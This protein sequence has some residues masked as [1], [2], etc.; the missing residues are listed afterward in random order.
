MNLSVNWIKQYLTL[1]DITPKDLA[2][3]LTMA[4]VEVEEVVEQAKQLEGIVVGQ[5]KEIVKHPQADKL[6]ICNTAIGRETVQ[7]VCG[8]SNLKENMLV[9]V[10]T[11]GSK[12]RWHGQGD[13]VTL[14]PA[15][16]RGQASHGMIVASSEIG[17]ED[18]FPAASDHIIL[19]LSGFP[20][21]PGMPLSEALGLN[22]VILEIDNKSVTH[23]PD[24]WGQY[25]LAREL[26]AVY[27]T[28]LKALKI[29]SLKADKETVDLQLTASAEACFRLSAV[30][31]D[32]VTVGESPWWLK[33]A[34]H[35]VGIRSIN[36]IVDITNYV[37]FD[38]GHPLHAFDL[39]ATSGPIE[40]K[41]LTKSQNITT[42]DGVK[43]KL[44]PGMV[45]FADSKQILDVAG[46]MG[47][48]SSEIKSST[49]QVLLTCANFQASTIRRMSTA[50]GLRT[51]ASSRYEKSLD[52][53]LTPQA[54]AQAVHLIKQVC[55]E[56]VVASKI[57]DINRA[58]DFQRTIVVPKDM[59]SRL[60]GVAIPDAT[61]KHIL[62]RLHF[63]VINKGKDWHVS[64]PSFR[65]TKDIGIPEDL[66]EE[67][68]RIYGYEN[69]VPVMPVITLE[70]PERNVMFQLERQLK[71]LLVLHG[72]YFEVV[73]YSFA[74]N[75]WAQF[76][77]LTDHQVALANYLSDDQKF[78]RTSLLPGLL[79]KVEEN[80]RWSQEF[81]FYEIGRIYRAEKGE[82]ATDGSDK[83]FLPDQP[84]MLAGVSISRDK[85]AQTLYLETKGL[86]EQILQHYSLPYEFRSE[87]VKFGSQVLGIQ[88]HDQK[89]GLLGTLRPEIM[90]EHFSGYNIVWW[91]INLQKMVKHAEVRRSFTAFP[92]F[93]SVVRDLAI[94]VDRTI[95]WGDIYQQLV[96]SSGLIEEIELFDVFES[97][98]LGEGKRSLAFSLTFRSNEKTLESAEIDSLVKRI[99]ADLTKKFG[100]KQR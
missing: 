22:D 33:R 35:S 91:Q 87:T 88:A 4:T 34:L 61:V 16:I 6:W 85:S 92:K 21:K 19:D 28:K 69:I 94:V 77:N 25:G 63:G 29:P 51:E 99:V 8:G 1:P 47:G 11:V 71:D 45:V 84:K 18:L 37:M 24:L 82:F 17:L 44:E 59:F 31:L 27:D 42:L 58:P 40:V 57:I 89:F 26:A 54:I 100:A 73:N 7:I 90:E 83:H 43:R 98:Q 79:Q 60:A 97:P 32:N 10:A 3:K 76:L 41:T 39:A 78:L 55:P 23:R 53:L 67:V 68:I 95:A 93:P 20:G 13:L 2:L 66:V 38:L 15:K 96:G 65:A 14:E 49:K 48:Q 30:V 12:V 70:Q 80:L 9:A 74:V 5:I 81:S 86:I 64:V 52:P 62:T 72:N 36:N 56:A 75:N 46:I 50:L